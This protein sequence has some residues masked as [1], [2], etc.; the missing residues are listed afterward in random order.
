[1]SWRKINTALK[2]IPVLAICERERIDGKVVVYFAVVRRDEYGVWRDEYHQVHWPVCYMPLPDGPFDAME[3]R[4]EPH[5]R[6]HG[7]ELSADKIKKTEINNAGETEG[8][9]DFGMAN[10]PDSRQYLRSDSTQ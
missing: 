1:M 6:R 9:D 5:R 2:Q 3:D 4:D 8:M 7:A 10:H